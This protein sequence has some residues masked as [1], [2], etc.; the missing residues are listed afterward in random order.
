VAAAPQLRTLVRGYVSESRRRLERKLP[1][2]LSPAPGSPAGVGDAPP[3]IWQ[4]ASNAACNM[5]HEKVVTQWKGTAHAAAVQTLESRGRQRDLYC[6]R[7]HT[8]GFLQ[9]GGTRN[10]ET[11]VGYYA[12][13]GCES[14]HGPSVAHVRTQKKTDTRR[15]VPASVCLQCHRPDQSPEPFDYAASLELVLGPNHGAP[16][17]AP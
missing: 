4:Y 13:V 2:G 15:Q 7:C 17:A 5:C 9:P 10:L 3:E 12:E 16:V 11:A 8:T 14:C 1:T 6:L